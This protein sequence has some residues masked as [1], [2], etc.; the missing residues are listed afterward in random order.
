MIESDSGISMVE[1]QKA[2]ADLVI[3]ET[4]SDQK[5]KPPNDNWVT[6]EWLLNNGLRPS[7]TLRQQ[8]LQ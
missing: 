8:R 5:R 3:D 6:I 7:E 2:I 1:E 4:L